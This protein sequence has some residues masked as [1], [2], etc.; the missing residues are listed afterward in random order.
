MLGSATVSV[1]SPAVEMTFAVVDAVYSFATPGVNAP[2]LAGAPIVSASVAGTVPP[3]SPM[4]VP[5]AA[6][7]AF[8]PP[9]TGIVNELLPRSSVT[10]VPAAGR[11]VYWRSLENT[12]RASRRPAGTIASLACMS[13]STW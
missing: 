8:W 3:A 6:A 4:A 7:S 13:K 1:A 10:C 5:V 12:I 2:K 11:I 9:T